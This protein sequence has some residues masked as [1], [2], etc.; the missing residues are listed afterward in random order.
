MKKTVRNLFLGM[1]L[2]GVVFACGSD[3]SNDPTPGGSGDLGTYAGNIMVVDDPQSQLGYILNAKVTVSHNGSTATVKVTG[4]PGF[5]REYTGTYESQLEGYHRINITKQTKPVEKIAGD[6]VSI[7]DNKLTISID[8][9]NDEVSVYDE[10]TGDA[11]IT[12]KGK[13]EMVGTSLLKE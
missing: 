10:P 1:L 6:D 8:L 4:D 9:A 12:I 5:D 13:L 11:K 7:S 3:D 2:T